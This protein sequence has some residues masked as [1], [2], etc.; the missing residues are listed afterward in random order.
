MKHSSAPLMVR[1]PALE[2]LE[3][4]NVISSRDL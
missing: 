1:S 2:S 4:E 3:L